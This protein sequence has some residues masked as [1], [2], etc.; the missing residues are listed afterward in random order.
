MGLTCGVRSGRPSFLTEDL[1][2]CNNDTV[3][4][5]LK[6]VLETVFRKSPTIVFR[7]IADEYLLVPIRRDVAD[8]DK[9][10]TLNDV[11]AFIWEQI[12]GAR[13]VQQIV[14]IVACEYE[15]GRDDA[16]RD[17]TEYLGR[18]L[19]IGAIVPR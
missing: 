6:E 17:V 7:K 4:I 12:D 3:V 11:G 1:E 9:I 10:Y 15:V 19:K 14:E 2:P 8:L 18:L 16:E 5:G 13:S